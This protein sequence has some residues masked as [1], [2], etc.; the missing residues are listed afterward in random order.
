[1][2]PLP[3]DPSPWQ[4]WIDVGGTFTDCIACLPDGSLRTH[5]LLSTGRYPTQADAASTPTLWRDPALRR[6]PAGYF[7]GYRFTCDFPGHGQ[8]R[9]DITR[10]RELLKWEPTVQLRGG[11]ELTVQ[12]SGRDKLIGD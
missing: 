10:A 5:K 7:T 1:M 11:L 2:P 6:A 12:R 9:P 8:D 3:P 4:F